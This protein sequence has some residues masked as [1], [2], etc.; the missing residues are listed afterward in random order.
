MVSRR[1]PARLCGELG[2]HGKQLRA[3]LYSRNATCRIDQPSI[4]SLQA[5]VQAVM[6]LEPVT[7]KGW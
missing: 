1:S 7:R 6:T 4:G 2:N 5:P 3:A